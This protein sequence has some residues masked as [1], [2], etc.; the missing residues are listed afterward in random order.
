MA[1]RG[2][3]LLAKEM[4]GIMICLEGDSLNA[5]NKIIDG[6]A[7][8]SHIGTILLDIFTLVTWFFLILIVIMFLEFVT[9]LLMH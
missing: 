4:G 1:L 9:K 6:R 3:I 8:L 5:I 7:D 2:S